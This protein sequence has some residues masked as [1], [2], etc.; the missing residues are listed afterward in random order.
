MITRTDFNGG[1]TVVTSGWVI[2][3]RT[4]LRW[5]DA[6]WPSKENAEAIAE[7]H[8]LG[9]VNI[10]PAKRVWSLSRPKSVDWIMAEGNG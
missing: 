9:P 6:L 5:S 10:I 2:L 4:G 7:A 1:L 8:A 3:T